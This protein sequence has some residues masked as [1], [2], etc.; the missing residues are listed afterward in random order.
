MLEFVLIGILYFVFFFGIIEFAWMS[1]H[2]QTLL[3]GCVRAARLGAVNGAGTSPDEMR[4]MVRSVSGL[5]VDD[6][7]IEIQYYYNGQWIDAAPKN[8]ADGSCCTSTAPSGSLLRVRVNGWRHQLLTGPLFS[9]LPKVTG[10]S[11]PLTVEA[12]TRRES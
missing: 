10:G 7:L 12:S 5:A 9:W 6:R 8:L 2:R 11:L 3:L 4:R 1:S